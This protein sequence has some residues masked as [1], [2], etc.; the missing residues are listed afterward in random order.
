[1]TDTGGWCCSG[2]WTDR[3]TGRWM[4]GGGGSGSGGRK[5]GSVGRKHEIKP[6]NEREG[7]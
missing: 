5:G 7:G 4:D 3:W 6:R 2:G 1:M